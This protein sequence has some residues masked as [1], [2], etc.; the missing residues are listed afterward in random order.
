M[1]AQD[2]TGDKD[3]A[4]HE[5]DPE[6]SE[7]DDFRNLSY[8]IADEF[9]YKFFPWRLIFASVGFLIL[10]ILLIVVISRSQ[11]LAETKQILAIEERIEQLETVF[12]SKLDQITKELNRLD[13]TLASKQALPVKA[14]P[15]PVKVLSPPEEVS[16]PQEKEKNDL[17]PKI[18]KVQAGDSLYQISLDYGLTIEQLCSYNN[19]EANAKIYPG[20]ELKLAP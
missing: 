15:S 9:N 14:S 17:K 12:T 6:E 13:Q 7:F 11:D 16:S 5:S 4:V 19:M 1:S 20:Q 10:I 2:R 8:E 18:H 3:F